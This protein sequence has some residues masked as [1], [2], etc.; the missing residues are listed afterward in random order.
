[1][2]KYVLIGVPVAF[3][4]LWLLVQLEPTH[5]LPLTVDPKALEDIMKQRV[6]LQKQIRGLEE[7]MKATNQ[8]VDLVNTAI[9][10]AYTHCR[11]SSPNSD[12][13]QVIKSLVKQ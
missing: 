5:K 9:K 1:M 7:F 10:D 4:V 8:D 6:E 11:T 2:N 3:I 12:F 13:C